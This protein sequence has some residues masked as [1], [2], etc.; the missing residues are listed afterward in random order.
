MY[1]PCVQVREYESTAQLLRTENSALGLQ[2]E[3]TS[4]ELRSRSHSLDETI[5]EISQLKDTIE[6]LQSKYVSAVNEKD[7]AKADLLKLNYDIKEK[8]LSLSDVIRELNRLRSLLEETKQKK[9]KSDAVSF[10][11]QVNSISTCFNGLI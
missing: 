6:N 3:H 1:F 2:L 7:S 10:K 5:K 8:E 4:E 11:Q 9:E